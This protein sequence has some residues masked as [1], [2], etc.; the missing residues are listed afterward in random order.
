MLDM[1]AWSCPPQVKDLPRDTKIEMTCR[2]C[3]R[4]W[5]ESVQ[6]LVE[7]HRL[8]VE[9]IDLLEWKYRCTDPAC[10]GMVHV[11]VN[12]E[13]PVAPQVQPRATMLGRV[14]AVER[15]AYPVKAVVK[16]RISAPV[17][18]PAGRSQLDLPLLLPH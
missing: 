8:G 12:G 15:M 13:A 16:S 3:K 2:S 11:A 10:G 1:K 5:G 6:N 17:A 18:V 9:F 4:Q 7:A 14:R